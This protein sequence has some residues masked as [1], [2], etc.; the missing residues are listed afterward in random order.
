MVL[1]FAVMACCASTWHYTQTANAI[2]TDVSPRRDEG[3][4]KHTIEYNQ[5]CSV[6]NTTIFV[7]IF[8]R[9]AAVTLADSLYYFERLDYLKSLMHVQFLT[10]AD[11]ADETDEIVDTWVENNRDQYRSISRRV[12]D[13][14][15]VGP[16]ARRPH[17][18]DRDRLKILLDARRRSWED[19]VNSGLDMYLSI[20]ADVFLM[21]PGALAD[22]VRNESPI[23]APLLHV[24][25]NRLG[26]N[27]FADVDDRGYYRRGAEYAPILY[28]RKRG[29]HDVPVVHSAFLVDMRSDATRELLRD[30]VRRDRD[31]VVPE[32]DVVLFS[33]LAR[34]HDIRQVVL[35]DK[36]YGV[37]NDPLAESRTYNE[38]RSMF[39]QLRRTYLRRSPSSYFVNE[40]LRGAYDHIDSRGGRA[41]DTSFEP[42]FVVTDS[43]RNTRHMEAYEQLC[44]D[45]FVATSTKR[46]RRSD[47]ELLHSDPQILIIRDLISVEDSLALIESAKDK[48]KRATVYNE[49]TGDLREATYRTSH[50]AWLRRDENAVVDAVVRRIAAVTGLDVALADALQIQRYDV[51]GGRYEP[52]V[53]FGSVKYPGLWNETRGNRLATVILY[54]NDAYHGGAT[55]FTKLGVKVQPSQG[56]GVFWYNLLPAGIGDYRTK[57]AACPSYPSNAS[58]EKWAANLWIREGQNRLVYSKWG[59]LIAKPSE[60]S[61]SL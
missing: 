37:M 13:A 12:D 15:Y 39:E 46:T 19:A 1:T 31:D 51:N 56:D 48:M 40:V 5:E 9:N 21:E 27:F 59:G 35:N 44:A 43:W 47:I 42:T 22:L 17:C 16:C 11:N 61:S 57:H 58:K 32:D 53:D 38:E 45:D 23:A 18:W 10:G 50:V 30:V 14:T 25:G 55:V 7:S 20:D 28:Y 36:F 29:I 54:L 41:L 34:R 6:E 60:P 24:F 33:T 2:G 52:H 4:T 3:A 8:A 49:S 26:S